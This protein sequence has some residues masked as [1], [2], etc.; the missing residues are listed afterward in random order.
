M[1]WTRSPMRSPRCDDKAVT[2]GATPLDRTTERRLALPFALVTFIWGSTWLVIHS[3]FG[4]VST[5]WSVSYRFLIGGA[6]MLLVARTMRLPLAIG[7]RGHGLAAV[8]GL[9]TFV[10]NYNLV[11]AAERHVTSG[12]VAVLFSL[13]VPCNALLGRAFL[14]QLLSR[15][16]LIGSAVAMLGVVLLFAHELRASGG[17][18][19]EVAIGT[20]L[21]LVA[22]LC[23]SIGGVVQGSAAGKLIPTASLLAWT[24]LW[25]AM[26]DGVVAWMQSGAPRID[27]RPA[28]LGGL[29]YLGIIASAV[30]FTLYYDLIRRIGAARAGYAN[31]LVP[32]IAMALSTLFEHYRWSIEAA[33]GGLL[34]LIG[35]ALAMR[36]RSAG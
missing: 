4:L 6:A 29:L 17:D 13:L 15:P 30:A 19:H 18:P 33:L 23:A 31:V 2:E 27:L 28:Y 9:A 21:T 7:W 32:V 25:G 8:V 5:Q 1:R 36:A 12:L 35:L 3:Q 24:M 34:T 16:F 22:V 14:G 26:L 11:Y 10:I 20:G